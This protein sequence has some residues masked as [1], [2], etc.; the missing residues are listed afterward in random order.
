MNMGKKILKNSMSGGSHHHNSNTGYP[1]HDP[2]FGYGGA[3]NGYQNYG[4]MNYGQENYGYGPQGYVPQ[5]YG[6]GLGG[7][8]A[9]VGPGYGYAPGIPPQNAHAYGT[10]Y[11]SNQG[12]HGHSMSILKAFDRDGDGNI[13]E[14]GILIFCFRF[15]IINN[16]FFF[17][18][19]NSCKANGTG[20][21]R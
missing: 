7:Y 17:R 9:P 8:G 10:G 19:C 18:F 1:N 5:N 21:F 4:H 6:N 12:N 13:T 16:K 14:N 15:L 11:P 2:N 20:I 3:P